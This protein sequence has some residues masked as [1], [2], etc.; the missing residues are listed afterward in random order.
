V[1]KV[2]SLIDSFKSSLEKGLRNA[3]GGTN[4]CLQGNGQ[5][6]LVVFPSSNFCG[7]FVSFL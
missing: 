6:N 1:L 2:P 3:P 5:D 7:P 4:L